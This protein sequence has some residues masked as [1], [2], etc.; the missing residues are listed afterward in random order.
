MADVR[1]ATLA[2]SLSLGL[3]AALAGC[4]SSVDA[5][6]FADDASTAD[7]ADASTPVV[8]ASGDAALE[9]A[10]TPETGVDATVDTAPPPTPTTLDNVC[11]RWSDAIC[12]APTKDCCTR[13]SIGY[14]AAGCRNAVNSWCGSLVAQVK[15]AQRTFNASQ[16]DACAQAW[17]SL[18]AT[19]SVP[20]V[21]YVKG[22]APCAQMFPG[23]IG[24][25]KACTD[26]NDCIAPAG[27]VA[28]CDKSA[29]T[30]ATALIVPK[31]A[32]CSY[33]QT[34]L[35][36]C[37]TGYYCPAQTG[38]KCKAVTPPGGSCNNVNDVSCGLGFQCA[39]DAMGNSKCKV[40]LPASAQC[41]NGL[42]CASWTCNGLNPFGG[43]GTCSDPYAQMASPAICQGVP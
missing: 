19:C 11:A 10:S 13:R 30:C 35:R 14:D 21:D 31:D 32:A 38:G 39:P 34:S 7:A 42:Q 2:V 12:A 22:Y 16:F 1:T 41:T 9:E 24:A 37:D 3:V 15:A 33:D 26:D 18:E 40:G 27:G 8:D 17:R 43:M 36:L 20:F 28:F 6:T 29:K 23:T 5:S 25:G 4:G